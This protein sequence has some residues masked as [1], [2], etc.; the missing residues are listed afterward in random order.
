MTETL[1]HLNEAIEFIKGVAPD[2]WATFLRQQLIEGWTAVIG[3]GLLYV[4]AAS[5]LVYGLRSGVK[6]GWE[7]EDG[8][9]PVFRSVISV[10]LGGA[11]TI[12]A[13]VCSDYLIKG[14]LQINNPAY[15]AIKEFLP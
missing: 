4:V 5:L 11:F 13:L 15:Y 12:A 7:R 3:I 10:G 9:T 2:V 14:I 8:S 1:E 6:N